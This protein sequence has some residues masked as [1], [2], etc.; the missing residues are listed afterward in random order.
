[1]RCYKKYEWWLYDWHQTLI[2]IQ[3]FSFHRKAGMV[4]ESKQDS[5][6]LVFNLWIIGIFFIDRLFCVSIARVQHVVETKCA[7]KKLILAGERVW[8]KLERRTHPSTFVDHKHSRIWD[9]FSR[10]WDTHA[11]IWETDTV[12]NVAETPTDAS[13]THA[14]S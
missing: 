12:P 11:R 1:M 13:E 3:C 5:S 7:N 9:T 14:C 6:H 10:I 4:F 2:R 8:P